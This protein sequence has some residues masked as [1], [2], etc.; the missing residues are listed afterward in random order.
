[1]HPDNLRKK[2][3]SGSN[4]NRCIFKTSRQDHGACVAR[5]NETKA[6]SEVLQCLKLTVWTTPPHAGAVYE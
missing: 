4:A 1:M 5:H 2:Q 6:S 3:L